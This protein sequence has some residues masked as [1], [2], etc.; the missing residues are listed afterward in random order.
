MQM[1]AELR[2]LVAS[3]GRKVSEVKHLTDSVKPNKDEEAKLLLD[4]TPKMVESYPT[5]V[6]AE[7]EQDVFRGILRKSI[8]SAEQMKR[9]KEKASSV[10]SKALKKTMQNHINYVWNKILLS[11]YGPKAIKA[12]AEDPAFVDIDN[13]EDVTPE[14]KKRRILSAVKC[15]KSSTREEIVQCI[16]L[17]EDGEVLRALFQE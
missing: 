10:E 9:Y 7:N 1:N 6:D 2:T 12:E 13:D 16:N 14:K 3:A 8:Y 4:L 11:V 17:D 15:L 5:R